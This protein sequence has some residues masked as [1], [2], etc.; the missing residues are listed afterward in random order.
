MRTHRN[1]GRPATL[2]RALSRTTRR[3]TLTRELADFSTAAE[4]LEL[5]TL[6][7]AQPDDDTREVRAILARQAA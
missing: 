1:A 4:R 6:L 3:R 7:D 5:E 2:T